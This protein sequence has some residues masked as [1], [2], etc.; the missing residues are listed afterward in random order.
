MEVTHN[1]TVSLV[2]DGSLDEARALLETPAARSALGEDDWRD[3]SVYLVQTRAEA[4]SRRPGEPAAADAASADAAAADVVAAGLKELGPEP[5]LLR[6]YEAYMHNAFARMYNARRFDD[7]R[8]ILARGLAV[9]PSSATL[10]RDMASL[11][12]H[13]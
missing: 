12:A 4:V 5:E 3:L 9:H 1:F 6:S 11:T 13:R 8:A 10:A 2:E 7:A